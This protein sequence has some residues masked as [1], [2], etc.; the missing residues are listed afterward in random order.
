MVYV[1]V[2]Y[3]VQADRTP[4]FLNYLRQYLVHVQNSVFEGELTEG[5]TEEVEGRLESMLED[6]ES[7]MVYRMSSKK[8]VNRSV[9][10]DDPMDDQ[11]FL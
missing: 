9:F 4:K 3:D 11:Q 5:K 1:I 10:G 7:I 6:G 8:Y 2:V